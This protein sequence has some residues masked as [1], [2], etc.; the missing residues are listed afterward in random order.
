MNELHFSAHLSFITLV[1]N[2]PLVTAFRI[3]KYI[4]SVRPAYKNI[5]LSPN[6]NV[7]DTYGC[8]AKEICKTHFGFTIIAWIPFKNEPINDNR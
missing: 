3:S 4:Q 8:V 2:E 6:I 1:S 5:G 7:A